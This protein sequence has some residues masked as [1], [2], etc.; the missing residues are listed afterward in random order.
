MSIEYTA[1]LPEK[2]CWK[3]AQQILQKCSIYDG[4]NLLDET[5][6]K[7]SF[8]LKSIPVREN[9]NEDVEISISG[10]TF[11]VIFHAASKLQ[12]AN[13]VRYLNECLI[14][15]NFSCHLEEI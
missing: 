15:F 2:I 8:K 3:N 10:S 14:I 4:W 12:R 13:C 1:P 5:P 9:W 11:S 6:S 7:M